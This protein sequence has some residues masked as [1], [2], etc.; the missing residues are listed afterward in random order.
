MP[1]TVRHWYN[2]PHFTDEKT[3]TWKSLFNFGMV[4]M[5]A[6][7]TPHRYT[8]PEDFHVLIPRTCEYVTI[9]GKRHFA[10]VVQVEDF[11][12]RDELGLSRWSQS[13]LVFMC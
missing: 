5:V 10:G 4:T 7:T 3:E 9:H 12:M 11:K 2:H 13:Y 1:G 6:T 8:L